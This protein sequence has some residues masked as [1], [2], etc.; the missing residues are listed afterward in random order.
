MKSFFVSQKLSAFR[1]KRN[2]SLSSRI[3]QT[4]GKP[5]ILLKGLGKSEVFE[6][7]KNSSKIVILNFFRLFGIIFFTILIS[8]RS[9]D[10]TQIRNTFN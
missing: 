6:L 10:T 7:F 1:S 3:I 8:L 9:E 4:L 5:L 2:K